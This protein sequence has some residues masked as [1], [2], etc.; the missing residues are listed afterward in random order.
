LA[1]I[2]HFEGR[3]WILDHVVP[4]FVLLYKLLYGHE[5]LLHVCVVEMWTVRCS[6]YELGVDVGI[7]ADRQMLF[8]PEFCT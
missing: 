4:L 5:L 2:Q 6:V 8:K 3:R 7:V 1:S